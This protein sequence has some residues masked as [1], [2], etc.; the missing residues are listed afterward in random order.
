MSVLINSLHC[1]GVVGVHGEPCEVGRK[2]FCG[3]LVLCIFVNGRVI[4][5]GV[6]HDARATF[7]DLSPH[8]FDTVIGF[9]DCSKR[10]WRG[11][12]S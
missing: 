3:Y 11:K 5:H 6:I 7:W 9:A 1:D 12:G 8:D 4:P 2:L 10:L